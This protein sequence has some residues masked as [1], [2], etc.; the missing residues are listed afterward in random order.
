MTKIWTVNWSQYVV[1][2]MRPDVVNCQPLKGEVYIVKP[3]RSIDFWILKNSNLRVG[4]RLL[5]AL[6]GGGLVE[7]EPSYRVLWLLK[8]IY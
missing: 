3:E 2:L 1:I 5:H 4:N 6:V 8:E 7:I